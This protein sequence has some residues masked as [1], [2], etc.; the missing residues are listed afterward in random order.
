VQD[1]DVVAAAAVAATGLM[2]LVIKEMALQQIF[3][4]Q[5][6]KMLSAKDLKIGFKQGSMRLQKR[7][8]RC[9]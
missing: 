5:V 7:I 4:L 9:Q 3:C 2:P 8:Q 6:Q 1:C